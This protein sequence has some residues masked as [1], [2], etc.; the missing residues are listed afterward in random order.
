[1]H[2]YVGPYSFL[3]LP[4]NNGA[5]QSTLVRLTFYYDVCSTCFQVESI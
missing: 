1:M 4:I 2:F 5:P 3:E